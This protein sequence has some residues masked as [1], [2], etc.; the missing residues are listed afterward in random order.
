MESI[1]RGKFGCGIFIDLRKAFDTVNHNILKKIEYY[2]VRG[3]LLAW[4]RS[5]LTGRKQYVFHNGES[6]D[7]KPVSCG[8]LQGSV[9]GPLLS[10]VYIN[11]L[12]NISSKLKLFLFGHVHK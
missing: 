8:V 7:L 2:G 1:D 3:T 4:F 9:L 5:Y 12:P 6:S 10:L 11:D